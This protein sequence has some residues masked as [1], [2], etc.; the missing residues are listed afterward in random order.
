MDESGAEASRLGFLDDWWRI[1]LD[2]AC[3]EMF[4]E[5]FVASVLGYWLLHACHGMSI[6]IEDHG[7]RQN[8]L[9]HKVQP[10]L[11]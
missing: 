6:G 9:D 5:L 10:A 3:L 2:Y 1:H 8:W 7:S 11:Q 4:T